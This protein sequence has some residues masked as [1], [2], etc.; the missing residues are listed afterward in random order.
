MHVI[1]SNG[2][3][4]NLM[5]CI[6]LRITYYTDSETLGDGCMKSADGSL[7]TFTLEKKMVVHE[8]E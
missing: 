2:G 4:P 1:A 8:S 7:H 5:K 3:H 6:I